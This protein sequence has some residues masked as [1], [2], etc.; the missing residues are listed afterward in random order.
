MSVEA[1]KLGF[2]VPAH[3]DDEIPEKYTGFIADAEN[4]QLINSVVQVCLG[5]GW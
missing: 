3:D 4:L 2:L 5:R 1:R